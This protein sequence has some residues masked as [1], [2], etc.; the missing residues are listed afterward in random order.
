MYLIVEYAD[1][2]SNPV[3]S[4][5]YH[6]KHNTEVLCG[7]VNLVKYLDLSKRSGTITLTSPKLFRS[8]CRTL[9]LHV[10]ALGGITQEVKLLFSVR[11]KANSH[12]AIHP[13]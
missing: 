2:L 6:L 9:L 13:R 12:D 8:C 5:E 11:F 3:N 4:K 1:V 10:K 7:P